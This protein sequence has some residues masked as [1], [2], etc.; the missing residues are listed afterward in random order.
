[1]NRQMKVTVVALSV[2]LG[3]GLLSLTGST[4]WGRSVIP[5]ARAGAKEPG[6]ASS[7]STQPANTLR[8]SGVL[9]GPGYWQPAL[10][11]D[12]PDATVVA[13]D[14]VTVA[15]NPAISCSQS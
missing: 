7:P 6:F 5:I 14:N 2:L 13:G 8:L 11:S 4:G 15:R 3:I 1:M 9:S 12:Y 10:L